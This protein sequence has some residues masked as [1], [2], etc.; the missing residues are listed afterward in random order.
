M[1]FC[2]IVGMNAMATDQTRQDMAAKIRLAAPPGFMQRSDQHIRLK[3]I[4][5]H[6]AISTGTIIRHRRRRHRFLEKVG[7]A[8]IRRCLNHP[9]LAGL[10]E[11]HRDRRNR[12]MRPASPVKIKHL[13]EIH[14]INMI[15]PQ[16]GYPLRRVALDQADILKYRVCR[17]LKPLFALHHLRRHNADKLTGKG[18]RE[19]PGLAD[20]LNQR[21]RFV[22]HEQINRMHPGISQVRENKI[23]NPVATTK[24]H[25]RL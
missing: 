7:N 22:L 9:E 17:P 20:M 3:Q 25:R 6:R 16:N 23:D 1:I 10:S 8:T 21:L 2:K 11:R 19:S 18:A 5:A 12:D 24:R 4:I 14:P 13:A 15:R